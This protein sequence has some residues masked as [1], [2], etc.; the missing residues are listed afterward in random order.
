MQFWRIILL[1]PC[2]HMYTLQST[3]YVLTRSRL[4]SFL[5]IV[6]HFYRNIIISHVNIISTDA[7]IIHLRLRRK[8][9]LYSNIC[10]KHQIPRRR[11]FLKIPPTSLCY[12]RCAS[13]ENF[14]PRF[15]P[16][17]SPQL[18]LPADWSL[19]PFEETLRQ[20]VLKSFIT[21]FMIV[22]GWKWTNKS[23]AFGLG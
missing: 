19:N 15:Q 17:N 9:Y 14:V 6:A 13:Y 5:S 20:P 7:D 23:S 18:S 8:R 2:S 4:P 21:G 10:S 1:T 16:N 11:S 22:M 12:Y 3:G